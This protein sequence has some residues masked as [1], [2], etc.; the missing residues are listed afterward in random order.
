MKILE[1]VLAEDHEMC[2]IFEDDTEVVGDCDAFLQEVP[3]NWDMIFFG[4]DKVIQ[5]MKTQ[6]FYQ[7]RRAFGVR[8]VVFKRKAMELV[9]KA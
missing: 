2:A 7:V 4:M 9:V 8:G 5:A 1:N 3:E 6:A